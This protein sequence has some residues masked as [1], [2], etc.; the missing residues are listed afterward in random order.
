MSDKDRRKS[1]GKRN[2]RRAMAGEALAGLRSPRVAKDLQDKSWR[3]DFNHSQLGVVTFSRSENGLT[4]NLLS[5]HDG[6][7]RTDSGSADCIDGDLILLDMPP[8]IVPM[9]LIR[10]ETL[11]DDHFNLKAEFEYAVEPN[12]SEIVKFVRLADKPPRYDERDAFSLHAADDAEED[13]FTLGACSSKKPQKVPEDIYRVE[14]IAGTLKIRL[15]TTKRLETPY[16]IVVTLSYTTP[17]SALHDFGTDRYKEFSIDGVFGSCESETYDGIEVFTYLAEVSCR[18]PTVGHYL[19]NGSGFHDRVKV[20]IELAS[21][22][23][24]TI[25]TNPSTQLSLPNTQFVIAD[26]YVLGC[27]YFRNGKYEDL[28][29]WSDPTIDPPPSSAATLLSAKQYVL[30]FTRSRPEEKLDVAVEN[31]RK[32]HA[33]T[34]QTEIA[35]HAS[36]SKMVNF[37]ASYQVDKTVVSEK[38]ASSESANRSGELMLEDLLMS[39]IRIHLK[40][41]FENGKPLQMDASSIGKLADKHFKLLLAY[42]NDQRFWDSFDKLNT[43]AKRTKCR[44]VIGVFARKVATMGGKDLVRY[45]GKIAHNDTIYERSQANGQI[46]MDSITSGIGS[47]RLADQKKARKIGEDWFLNTLIALCKLSRNNIVN[48]LGSLPKIDYLASIEKLAWIPK[49]GNRIKREPLVQEALRGLCATNDLV[50]IIDAAYEHCPQYSQRTNWIDC[51]FVVLGQTLRELRAIGPGKNKN[52]FNP[53]GKQNL[54]DYL[55]ESVE[56][57]FQPTTMHSMDAFVETDEESEIDIPDSLADDVDGD[58]IMGE[59]VS[60]A[61]GA[62]DHFVHDMILR[63][64]VEQELFAW[65]CGLKAIPTDAQHLLISKA[66]KFRESNPKA[67]R[68]SIRDEINREYPAFEPKKDFVRESQKRVLEKWRLWHVEKFATTNGSYLDDQAL[69]RLKNRILG[70][71]RQGDNEFAQSDHRINV[72]AAILE[73]ERNG[74]LQSD[75]VHFGLYWLLSGKT[76]SDLSSPLGINTQAIETRKQNVAGKIIGK[77]LSTAICGTRVSLSRAAKKVAIDLLIKNPSKG[78]TGEKKILKE[79]VDAVKQV[80]SLLPASVVEH[81]INRLA[82]HIAAEPEYRWILSYHRRRRL[83]QMK[84]SPHNASIRPYRHAAL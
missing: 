26:G 8:D 59:E 79:I 74:D 65:V 54:F 44:V 51:L 22:T 81:H 9:T 64:V 72:I 30:R 62:L 66:K 69:E 45:V 80:S 11:Y 75:D 27:A 67:K 2:F 73:L 5:R 55:R 52:A 40:H 49:K 63:G 24:T 78:G 68:E 3:E 58:C 50:V 7:N 29:E 53:S 16:P 38:N 12:A 60:N 4:W 39:A 57:L 17:E 31:I 34:I 47:K 42:L 43:E 13:T 32:Q 36:D 46:G 18:Q 71:T 28:S 77:F 19:P 82:G 83:T 21:R 37:A 23:S 6:L 41:L 1:I 35:K 15:S 84:A 76:D 61:N 33:E 25:I 14:W 20:R 48:Y 70:G 10:G 56:R